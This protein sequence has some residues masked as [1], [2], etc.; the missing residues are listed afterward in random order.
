MGLGNSLKRAFALRFA[1]NPQSKIKNRAKAIPTKGSTPWTNQKPMP[2]PKPHMRQPQLT[3]GPRAERLSA[4]LAP[5]WLFHSFRCHCSKALQLY[6]QPTPTNNLF[7]QLYNSRRLNSH[8]PS[9]N[10]YPPRSRSWS[11]P[12]LGHQL[13][14]S[15]TTLWGSPTKRATS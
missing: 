13:E 6:L 1:T 5:A 14:Q 11:E 3:A 4:V 2:C 7:P 8:P 10:L 15:P 12:R 9:R